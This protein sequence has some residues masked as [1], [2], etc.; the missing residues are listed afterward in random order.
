MKKNASEQSAPEPDPTA[1]PG[2]RRRWA[3]C[4]WVLLLASGATLAASQLWPM[5]T[6]IVRGL[7]LVA[8]LGLWGGTLLILWR[9]NWSRRLLLAL[10]TAVVIILVLPGRDFD[11]AALRRQYVASLLAYENAPYVWGGE[12][13]R[14]V[15]C[16]G[17][18]RCGM[19]DAMARLGFQTLNP[20]LLRMGMA[21]WWSDTTAAGLEQGYGDRLHPTL[22]APSLNEIDLGQVMPGDVAVSV[23]GAHTLAYVGNG[24]WIAAD[25]LIKRVVR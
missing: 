19:M 3:A 9:S 6:S 22:A 14:G 1:Q 4:G 11:G 2:G 13:S 10:A 7:M 5:R 20:E 18:V 15:D 17:L 25:P 12:T 8:V 23:G 21:V 24:A 16:S